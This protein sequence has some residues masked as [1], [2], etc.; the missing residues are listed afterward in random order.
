[1]KNIRW[2]WL[3]IFLIVDVVFAAIFGGW[4]V[5][6]RLDPLLALVPRMASVMILV[7]AMRHQ[8]DIRL[9]WLNYGLAIF[10]AFAVQMLLAYLLWARFAWGQGIVVALLSIIPV[11]VGDWMIKWQTKRLIRIILLGVTGILMSIITALI[12][13]IVYDRA[14]YPEKADRP[15]LAVMTSLPIVWGNATTGGTEGFAAA[16]EGN[17]NPA[18]ALA[19]LQR[20][21]NVTLL[22]A[23]DVRRLP[24]P[25]DKDAVLFLAH[26]NALSPPELVALDG[27]IRQGGRALILAD[28]FLTWEPPF[29]VGD[30]RNPPITSLLTPMLD[31]W[32]L[33]LALPTVARKYYPAVWDDGQRLNLQSSGVFSEIRE[34]EG[35]S[36]TVSRGGVRV[37]CKVGKGKAILLSDADM[38]SD[39]YWLQP[40]TIFKDSAGSH[41]PALW[42]A[43]NFA[44]VEQQLVHM[45]GEKSENL[46]TPVWMGERQADQERRANPIK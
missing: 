34:A 1:M 7:W 18:P 39:V 5:L 11:V 42:Q 30:P 41:G 12:V 14:A 3:L 25:S 10:L 36:C 8:P 13:R 21:F 26:P 23:I 20:R 9:R 29:A 31:H 40:A 17:A 16:L 33:D 43:G 2:G 19:I 32:G 15:R 38:L 6:A 24:K 22:D 46:L 44:W 28:A 27:W 35:I 4:L 37:D 45:A